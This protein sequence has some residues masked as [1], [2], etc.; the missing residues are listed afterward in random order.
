M[1]STDSSGQ[2]PY[3]DLYRSLAGLAYVMNGKRSHERLRSEA[4]V[5]VDRASLSCCGCWPVRP[6]PCGWAISRSG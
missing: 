5:S 4:G 6:N 1:D 2:E 3:R